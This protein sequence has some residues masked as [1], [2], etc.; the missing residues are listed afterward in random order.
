MEKWSKKHREGGYIKRVN[1][2]VVV[3]RDAY[4]AHYRRLKEKY[5]HINLKNRLQSKSNAAVLCRYMFWVEKWE[6]STD[7]QKFVY[8]DVGIAAFLIAMWE[9]ER[10]ELCKQFPDRYDAN[11][12]QSFVDLGAGNGFLVY[13]LT[14][15]G[16]N[17][18]GIDIQKR[19]IWDKFP[20]N[21]RN[22][23]EA[24]MPETVKYEG[25]DWILA[26]HSDELTPWVP[27][28]AARTNARFWVLP[29]CEWNFDKRFTAKRK[30]LSRYQT[31]LEYVKEIAQACGYKAEVE[32]MRIPS[33]RNVSIV[34]RSRSIDVNDPD[35]LAQI[36]ENQQQLLKKARFK[37]FE[38]R[39]RDQKASHQTCDK[40]LDGESHESHDP[41]RESDLEEDEMSSSADVASHDEPSSKRVKLE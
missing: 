38:P 26:N 12:R 18:Y 28:I 13:I 27:L 16:Y 17:G 5:A 31:Y 21:V 24:I 19:K 11:F 23:E 6:E 35:A 34:G 10:E 4:T 14:S 30:N 20:S 15:E 33:T 8:E 25:I 40:C 7:P 1:H 32:P 41:E 2:D 37:A 39:A 29:C 22:I 3:P 36:T 9:T